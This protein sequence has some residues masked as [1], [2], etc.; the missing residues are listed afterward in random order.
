MTIQNLTIPDRYLPLFNALGDRITET[1][2]N[3]MDSPLAPANPLEIAELLS[4]AGQGQK[5]KDW[6]SNHYRLKDYLGLLD[7]V[8]YPVKYQIN[9][10]ARLTGYNWP[11]IA[12]DLADCLSLVDTDKFRDEE[13]LA[14]LEQTEP[15]C[16][17]EAE[18]TTI[19]QVLRKVVHDWQGFPSLLRIISKRLERRLWHDKTP[20]EGND[21]TKLRLEIAAYLAEHD[22]I[23]RTLLKTQICRSFGLDKKTFEVIAESLDNN[24]SKPK[25]KLYDPTEFMALPT[26][27]ANLLA[28][29]FVAMGVTLLAGNPGGGKTTLLYDL[30][31]CVINGE[32]FLGEVPTRQGPVL[33]IN[34]DERHNFSQDKLINRGI[35]HSYKV[36]LDWDVSQW[37]ILEQAVEDLRPALVIV[38]S[39]NSIHNDPNFDENCAQASQTIKKLEQLS[40]KHCTP[41]AIT[42]HLNKSKDNKGVNK[43]RG[44][45]AIAASVSS[46][47]ILDGEG[48]TKTLR[49]D[50]VRGSEPLNVVI[51]MNVEE[52]RFKLIS[53]NVADPATKS[54]AQRLKEFYEQHPGLYE[55]EEIN[56]YLPGLDSKQLRNA[57][58]RLL[59]TPIHGQPFIKRPS[60]SNPRRKVYG[61]VL[62]ENV[63]VEKPVENS[64]PIY[65]P[66]H[67]HEPDPPKAMQP[68]HSKDYSLRTTL[69]TTNAQF[70][71]NNGC[72][73]PS[74]SSETLA[75]TE[76]HKRTTNTQRQGVCVSFE[77]MP[78]SQ[79][80][81]YTTLDLPPLII[82]QAYPG[83]IFFVE[84]YPG[85]EITVTRL[86][87]ENGEW[88]YGN[89]SFWADDELF[90]VSEIVGI[91]P[92]LE[93]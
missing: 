33:F 8:V 61:I 53:G 67:T 34:C 79:M 51:E 93:F 63:P 68:I 44:S 84:Q 24:S 10:G 91:Q 86:K 25:A 64:P 87:S 55:I 11:I 58:N 17:D 21:P 41:V 3:P 71:H 42:H 43:L 22:L 88:F 66:S 74:I 36:L 35:T 89:T 75:Q 78:N 5:A 59:G 72:T 54:L 57:L 73:P 23:A 9:Q 77:A 47:L 56:Y 82:P 81:V 45:T 19:A 60:E 13:V 92:E 16:A 7:T 37:A 31:G 80:A 4:Y 39:F 15:H 90:H 62:P 14:I 20:K 50:K 18:L 1:N 32:E 70:T 52:G 40:A 28:P 6:L 29:G 46:T 12:E 83:L 49:Q 38:D 30:A 69:G 76:M 27:G 65:P 48:T 85:V 26:T 2:G